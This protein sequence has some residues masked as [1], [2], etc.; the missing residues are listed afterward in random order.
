MIDYIIATAS[1]CDLPR[2]WLDA[3]D[4]PFIAYGYTV[5]DKAF[6]DDCREENR[7]AVYAGMR[8]G[9]LLKTSMINKFAYLEFF[10]DLLGTGKDVLFC[11]MS[12]K[13]SASYNNSLDAADEVC[14]EFPDQ[15]LYVMDT[16]CISGGLGTLV[17]HL[18]KLKESGASFDEAIDWGEENK[19]RISHRFTVDNLNYLK[20]GGRVSNASALIG[21]VLSIKPVLYVPDEGTLDVVKKA[22]GR[23]A[24]LKSIRDGVLNDLSKIDPTGTDIHILH[25]DCRK[26]AEW[27]LDEVKNA[28][29]QVGE[30]TITN[31]GVVI[32]AHCGPACSPRS[33]CAT[34]AA[35]NNGDAADVIDTARRHHAREPGRHRNGMRSRSPL[36]VLLRSV[37]R[38]ASER[39]LF[40]RGLDSAGFHAGG[41]RQQPLH[42]PLYASGELVFHLEKLASSPAAQII[43]HIA[44]AVPQLEHGS[45]LQRARHVDGREG[46][47]FRASVERIL[48][49]ARRYAATRAQLERMT[50]RAHRR[51]ALV[52]QEQGDRAALEQNGMLFGPRRTRVHHYYVEQFRYALEQRREL[53]HDGLRRLKPGGSRQHGEPSALRHLRFK[54]IGAGERLVYAK[55]M[56]HAHHRRHIPELQIAIEKERLVSPLACHERADRR[57]GAFARPTAAAHDR[58]HEGPVFHGRGRLRQVALELQE[59]RCRHGRYGIRHSQ[60]DGNWNLVN[61]L[62]QL[63]NGRHPLHRQ[64]ACRGRLP[65][66]QRRNPV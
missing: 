7:E 64:R 44:A 53:A 18:V 61:H 13:M 33:T 58:Y 4:V 11:D 25:A 19:L 26:D 3:H 12:M 28:Y 48:E 1:T 38:S 35:P 37:A 9:D 59:P 55:R 42:N 5:G 62:K 65:N 40:L 32:G 30:I 14:G 16:R 54:P 56:L 43:L 66:G 21:T 27:V 49:R 39:R 52:H 60:L 57:Y 6:V 2:T 17:A 8:E 36:A 15:R 24:A 46:R 34:A 41:S 22:R 63:W 10:R 47:A 50:A 45:P 20:A 23:K 51:H 29:P 31:L